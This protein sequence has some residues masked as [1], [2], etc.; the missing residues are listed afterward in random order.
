MTDFL[1]TLV[2]EG[3]MEP[4]INIARICMILIPVIIF[5]E[6]ARQYNLLEVI[7][8]RIQPFMRLM[9]LPKEA[10][11]PLLAALLFGIVLGSAVII[12]YSREG[13]L[14]K[15]DL[16]LTGVFMCI[17]HSVIEDTIIFASL[18]ANPVIFS[19]TRITLAILITRLA[20]AY[21]DYRDRGKGPGARG[22]GLGE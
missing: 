15:R 14:K 5:I 4:I 10:A 18:G 11:F 9:S 22:Q 2:R 7:S 3:I 17:S 20:A 21:L 16:L 1:M 13:F 12:E 19:L 8:L 6:A